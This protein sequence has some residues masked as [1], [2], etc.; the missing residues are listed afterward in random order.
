[1]S[2]NPYL[3]QDS[4]MSADRRVYVRHK[5]RS[6]AYIDLGPSNGG[7]VLN[8]SESGLALS[9]A[10][11]L[12]G[13][14]LPCMRFK[15]PGLDEAIEAQAR[16]VWMS[17]SKKEAGVRFEQL[18]ARD[19]RKINDWILAEQ[20]LDTRLGEAAAFDGVTAPT[21]VSVSDSSDLAE[22]VAQSSPAS[23]KREAAPPPSTV[24]VG[25]E[26]REV[27]LV[28]S[29][30]VSVNPPAMPVSNRRWVTSAAII[31]LIAFVS[32]GTGVGIERRF[33][34]G[35]RN[36]A[37]STAAESAKA[38][39]PETA[40]SATLTAPEKPA[41]ENAETGVQSG[42]AT[43]K[44][45]TDSS[46]ASLPAAE[47]PKIPPET[48]AADADRKIKVFE[49]PDSTNTIGRQL[50]RPDTT[51]VDKSKPDTP[52]SDTSRENAALSSD[53][54]FSNVGATLSMDNADRSRA[55]SVLTPE[56][57]TTPPPVL[58]SPPVQSMS[59]EAPRQNQTKPIPQETALPGANEK[60]PSPVPA[61]PAT[62]LLSPSVA[63]SVP[64]FPSMRIPPE[65][66]AQGSR[67][68]TSVQMGQLVT[69]TQPDYPPEA[70][71]KGI[72]GTVKVHATVGRDGGVQ[73]VEAN[74]PD[75]LAGAAMTA[76]R[77]WRYKPTLLDGQ[78]IEAEEEIVFV[79]R[80]SPSNP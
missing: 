38:Q 11:K 57:K 34:H 8:L 58:A 76:V 36:P 54:A 19:A 10:M 52:R 28:D 6:V 39:A 61:A 47:P 72:A 68:G 77:Q 5:L 22:T 7:L 62:K 43:D 37:Q 33:Q 53:R 32:F 55:A 46:K 65:L 23:V 60:A 13:G 14:E 4:A 20:G 41:S 67:A 79:F 56:H 26:E 66:K 59:A 42:L 16:I 49:R 35:R 51:R 70:I 74:G 17:E 1:V 73:S 27:G 48:H 45:V 40:H 64:P 80:L 69:R 18:Q 12:M 3:E 25:S 15:L 44:P 29:P 30:P 24:W 75:L 31:A 9:T 2:T 78:A 71:Q 63:V 50:S 21:S